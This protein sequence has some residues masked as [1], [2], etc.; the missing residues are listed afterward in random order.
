MAGSGP[1]FPVCSCSGRSQL[2]GTLPSR[3]AGR[4]RHGDLDV[5][6]QR[7]SVPVLPPALHP[8]VSHQVRVYGPS[9]KSVSRRSSLF[10]CVSQV[11][12]SWTIG[13][14]WVNLSSAHVGPA[15][16]QHF[17]QE[18]MMDKIPAPCLVCPRVSSTLDK[19]KPSSGKCP[20]CVVV[21]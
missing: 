18:S 4:G 20:R 3:H 9:R 15:H 13:M 6:R 14:H 7:G 10:L 1:V 5:S 16:G 11:F 21:T 17:K 19:P 12:W 8:G 2:C